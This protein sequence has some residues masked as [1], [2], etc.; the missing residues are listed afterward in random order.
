MTQT[1]SEALRWVQAQMRDACARAGRPENDVRLVAVSK[2]KP[3][4]DIRQALEA[5][6]LEFG[7]NYAQELRDKAGELVDEPRIR[8]HY[9]GPLQ[10]NKVKYV[11]GTAGL[12]HAVDSVRLLDA[13]ESRAAALDVTQEVLV[14]VNLAQEPQKAGAPE[15]DLMSLMRRFETS[16][17]LSCRGLMLMPPYSPDPEACRPLYRRLRILGEQLRERDLPNVIPDELSMGL[18]HDFPVAIEEGATLV[19]VGTA[20]FGDRPA[21]PADLH[22]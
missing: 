2:R 13:L 21:P 14:Q 6:Q 8:W 9:I 7:E 1:I 10:R 12:L 11:V 5:G 20:I 18:S 3:V 22:G 17:H 19:R 15:G 16:P 4:A